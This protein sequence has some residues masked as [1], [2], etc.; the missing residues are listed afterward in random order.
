MKSKNGL[1]YGTHKVHQLLDYI[2]TRKDC[3]MLTYFTVS[4]FIYDHRVRHDCTT[5]SNLTKMVP[6]DKKI[7]L[8][9]IPLILLPHNL[10]IWDIPK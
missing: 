8:V 5:L 4:D 1:E 2:I 9:P 6:F 10:D 3:K 7:L